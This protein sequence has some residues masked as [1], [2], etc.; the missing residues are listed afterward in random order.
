MSD[1]Q[2]VDL[3]QILKVE[4]TDKKMKAYLVVKEEDFDRVSLITEKELLSI[5]DKA[6][7]QFGI[8]KETI[9]RII[10]DKKWESKVLIAE[11]KYPIKGEDAKMEFFFPTE[12]SLR[13]QI[14]SDG[15]LDFKEVNVIFSVEKDTVL[16]K[17]TLATEGIFGID[18]LGNKV[19]APKGNDKALVAGSGT[20]KDPEDN[21]VIKSSTE[22]VVFYN[23]RNHTVEVHQSYLIP[24]SVNYA[25][26]NIHVKSSVEIKGDVDA[27]FTITTPYDVQVKGTVTLADITCGGILNVA[28][29]IIGDGKQKIKVTGDIHAA[30]INNH[31]INCGGSVYVS[32]EIRNAFIESDNEITILKQDGV[33]LGGKV[34]ATNKITSPFIGNNYNVQTEIEVGVIPKYREILVQK[35]S[36]RNVIKKQYDELQQRISTIAKNSPDSIRESRLEP[37]KNQWAELSQKLDAINAEIE[38]YDFEFINVPNPVVCVTKKIYPGVIIRIKHAVFEVKNELSR[39]VFKLVD[40]EIVYSGNS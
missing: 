9:D 15:H 22:G 25:V 26:G 20:Y 21:L 31:Y 23:S 10:S 11:G 8:I 17:K 34:C 2:K 30:Y 14:K 19:H 36:E 5:I 12:K 35:Q 18:V 39:V 38:Q 28:K 33:I 29:G 1:E 24:H 27:G 7:V 6:G 37:F 13:P 16:V 32:N 4:I 40:D 3:T